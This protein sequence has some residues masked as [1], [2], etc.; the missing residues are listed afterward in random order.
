MPLCPVGPAGDLWLKGITLIQ[1]T[2]KTAH[3]NIVKPEL[4][5]LLVPGS[6]L[7]GMEGCLVSPW[8]HEWRCFRVSR[9]YSTPDPCR[10]TT[11]SRGIWFLMSGTQCCGQ[12]VGDWNQ[13]W[14]GI[15]C[16]DGFNSR[17]TIERVLSAPNCWLCVGPQQHPAITANS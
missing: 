3:F 8:L 10:G 6:D 14:R 17:N 16:P 15:V 11:V 12:E 7:H 1:T 9:T 13:V 4:W 5:I 2:A